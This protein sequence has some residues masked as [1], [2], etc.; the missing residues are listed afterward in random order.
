MRGW[1][2]S[3]VRREEGKRPDGPREFHSMRAVLGSATS[4][5]DVF[6]LKD[7]REEQK[8]TS[9]FWKEDWPTNSI[10]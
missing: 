5:R 9:P 2:K 6:F 1:E 8:L 7:A 4:R 3:A 10:T